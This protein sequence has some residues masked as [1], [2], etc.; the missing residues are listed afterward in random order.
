MDET[1]TL[2]VGAIAVLMTLFF[3]WRGALPPDFAKGPRLIP[4]RFLMMLSA[5][6]VLMML[7]HLANLHGIVTGNGTGVGR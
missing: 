5:T 3:G 2:A 7:V 4:Y 1:T 6:G